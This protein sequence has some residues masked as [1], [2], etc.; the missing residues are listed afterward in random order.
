M[1]ATH[2]P[3]PQSTDNGIPGYPH[4]NGFGQ[5]CFTI[6]TNRYRIIGANARPDTVFVNGKRYNL[7]YHDPLMDRDT[8]IREGH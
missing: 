3:Y 2:Q 4:Q 7:A 1:T 5:D 6:D 8:F